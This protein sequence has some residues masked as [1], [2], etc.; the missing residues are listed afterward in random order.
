MSE[1]SLIPAFIYTSVTAEYTLNEIWLKS[2]GQCLRFPTKFVKSWRPRLFLPFVLTYFQSQRLC[3]PSSVF[4]SPLNSKSCSSKTKAE[5]LSF[6]ASLCVYVLLK[7]SCAAQRGLE[8]MWLWICAA[9]WL[10]LEWAVFPRPGSL[11]WRGGNR[12]RVIQWTGCSLISSRRAASL[13]PACKYWPGYLGA[14][15]LCKAAS[16]LASVLILLFLCVYPFSIALRHVTT[17]Q[18][19]IRASV[20]FYWLTTDTAS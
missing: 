19:L 14:A 5:W 2:L 17:F 3:T 16:R 7:C 11:D 15:S 12:G 4:W 1:Y 13:P 8:L 20:S 6:V 18:N 10:W 9:I